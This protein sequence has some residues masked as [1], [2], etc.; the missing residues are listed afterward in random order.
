MIKKSK[1]SSKNKEAKRR[2]GIGHRRLDLKTIGGG[3]E[4]GGA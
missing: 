2:R 4:V 3:R 1:Q